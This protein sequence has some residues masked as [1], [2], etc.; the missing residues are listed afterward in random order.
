M[1]E[2]ND[3]LG[4]MNQNL[5]D[6]GCDTKTIEQCMAYMEEGRYSDIFPILSQYREI[7]L[8]TV[9]IGQKRIDCLDYLIYK[10]KKL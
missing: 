6:A 7:L 2:V 10:L 1:A 8:G 9:H 5:I 4:S 3:A